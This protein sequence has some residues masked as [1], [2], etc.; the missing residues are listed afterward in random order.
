M[1]LAQRALYQWSVLSRDVYVESPTLERPILPFLGPLAPHV[2]FV[3]PLF[4]DLFPDPHVMTLRKRDPVVVE[5][6]ALRYVLP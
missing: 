1:V 4:C 2:L 5:A 3:P 6:I